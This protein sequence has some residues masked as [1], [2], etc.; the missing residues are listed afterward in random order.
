[1]VDLVLL[2]FSY[3]SCPLLTFLS[4]RFPRGEAWE[5][6]P[7]FLKSLDSVLHF[8]FQLPFPAQTP[9]SSTWIPG[10][11]LVF[12]PSTQLTGLLRNIP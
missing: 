5:I 12:S 6:F 3:P 9:I 2:S 10:F 1:M 4:C 8:P 11:L 7:H